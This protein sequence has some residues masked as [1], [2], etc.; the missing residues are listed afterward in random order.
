MPLQS[1]SLLPF[2]AHS[3]LGRFL[4]TGKRQMSHPF[5]RMVRRIWGTTGQTVLTSVPGKVIEQILWEAVPQPHAGQ[6]GHWEQ[7]AG[8]Y[9]GQICLTSLAA[10]CHEIMTP[11]DK[12]RAVTV[13]S[14]YF[15]KA[16]MC[17]PCSILMGKLVR[18]SVVWISVDYK[19]GG[20]LGGLP[21]SGCWS[22]VQSPAGSWLP[23]VSLRIC[24]GASTVQHFC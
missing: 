17:S 13:V 3:D 6:E 2:K 22:E 7:P 8:I 14:L 11:V 23:V 18:I 5:S 9:Q 21:G 24:N 12:G 16:L 10:F 15:S 4:V 19:R 1:C 20:R